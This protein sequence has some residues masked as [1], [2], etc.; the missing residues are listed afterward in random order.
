M[1]NTRRYRFSRP[2]HDDLS[3][4][5]I[6]SVKPRDAAMCNR[7][8]GFVVLYHHSLL[9]RPEPRSGRAYILPVMFF[10]RHAFSETPQPIALKLCHVIR[11][12]LYFINDFKNSGV[13]PKKNLG[14]K[15]MQNFGQF[16]TT[17]DFDREYPRNAA[18]YP[19]SERRTN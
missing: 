8:T 17:S 11:I 4:F 7:G 5:F 9:G 3:T 19:K 1:T 2:I 12:W 13:L 6:N 14:A 18:T 16:W 10:F 15:N